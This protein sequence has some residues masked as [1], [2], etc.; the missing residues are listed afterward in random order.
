MQRPAGFTLSE[1]VDL[2]AAFEFLRKLLGE[3]VCLFAVQKP[4][5]TD[6]LPE[7]QYLSVSANDVGCSAVASLFD[8]DGVAVS[9][10]DDHGWRRGV[11]VL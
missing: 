1:E 7:H 8:F 5:G 9:G 4:V 10:G 2:L 3:L 11:L 6:E